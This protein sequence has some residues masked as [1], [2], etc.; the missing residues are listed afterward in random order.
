M[1]EIQNLFAGYGKREILYDVS[2]TLPRGKH[3][4]LVGPN[5]CGK[6]TLLKAILGFLPARS[7]RILLDGVSVTDIGRSAL[8]RRVSY[9]SQARLCPQMTVEE[10]VLQGRYP[11]VSPLGHYREEDRSLARAAMERAGVLSYARS[12]LFT[13]SGGMRQTAYIAMAIAQSTDILLLDEPTSSL[14]VAHAVSLMKLLSS[15]REEGKTVLTVMHD[16]P[17]ALTYCDAVAV[18]REGRVIAFDTPRALLA[19]DAIRKTFGVA[20]AYEE[21]AGYFYRY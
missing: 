10:L 3:I 17:L 12:P 1:L 5:G 6:S 14:D 13:L 16:L 11:H 18:M 7:G 4:A 2:L 19:Q 8:A 9:L 20:V 21:G 15:L